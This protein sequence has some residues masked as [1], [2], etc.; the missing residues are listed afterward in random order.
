ML[1]FSK[2]YLT[3]ANRP[4]LIY[5]RVGD[6]DI[7]QHLPCSTGVWSSECRVQGVIP[8]FCWVW[9]KTKQSKKQTNKPG[10][11]E[12][13]FSSLSESLTLICLIFLKK[14]SL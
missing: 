2:L 9:P 6:R 14:V 7:V 13:D 11:N 8:K 10:K 4:V 5:V 3:M 12:W 1:C